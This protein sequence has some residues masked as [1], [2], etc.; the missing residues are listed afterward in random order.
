[1]DLCHFS[2]K[3]RLH[4]AHTS[5]KSRTVPIA[6]TRGWG[7]GVSGREEDRDRWDGR[8]KRRPWKKENVMSGSAW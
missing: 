5:D 1:M 7:H 8:V 3:P 4:V 6:R 2:T